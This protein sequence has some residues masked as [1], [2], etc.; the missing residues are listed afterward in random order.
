MTIKRKK[1]KLAK[2]KADTVSKAKA[3]AWKWFSRWVRLHESH[4]GYAVC[5]T[6]GKIYPISGK[7]CLQAGHFVPGRGNAILYDERNCHP[8]CF[9]CN[10][11]KGGAWVEY[12]QWMLERYG[13]DVVDELKRLKNVTINM[14]AS[15]HREIAEKYKEKVEEL[16]G[17]A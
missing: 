5:V 16:G 6:C 7:G 14:L 8:Q 11:Y 12:E 10:Q 9:V 3:E 1:S 17:W 13:Q 4:N 15:Q 2:R